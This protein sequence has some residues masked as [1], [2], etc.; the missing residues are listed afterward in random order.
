MENNSVENLFEKSND[1]SEYSKLIQDA[2]KKLLLDQ[3]KKTYKINPKLR[4]FP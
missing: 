2:N 1:L 4:L 3:K